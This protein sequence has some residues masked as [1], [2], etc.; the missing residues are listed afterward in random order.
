MSVIHS[1]V[2][3][4]RLYIIYN[5]I[6]QICI[7][8][9]N[10]FKGTTT[11]KNAESFAATYFICLSRI[12][13]FVFSFNGNSPKKLVKCSIPLLFCRTEMVE[14]RRPTVTQEGTVRQSGGA[15]LLH[16]LLHKLHA[17]TSWSTPVGAKI[18]HRRYEWYMFRY[19]LFDDQ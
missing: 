19:R 5:Y 14:H 7:C 10:F 9:A 6:V 2:G 13:V 1:S 12:Y 16:L 15:W 18:H 11:N 3:S 17:P 8:L 4:G